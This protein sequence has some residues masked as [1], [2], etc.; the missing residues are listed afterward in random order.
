MSVYA[1][2]RLPE[3]LAKRLEAISGLAGRAAT[4]GELVGLATSARGAISDPE[5]LCCADDSRHEIRIGD[6]TRHTH[7]VIDSLILPVILG[8]QAVVRS[9]SP[10][11]GAVVVLHVRPDGVDVDPAGAVVSFGL[12]REGSGAFYE[13][14]CPYINAFESMDEY[15]RWA[16]ATPE[17]VTIAMPVADAFA[18]GRAFAGK[19]C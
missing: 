13:V 5:A 16:A 14:G 3:A 17:A 10:L 19:G 15:E 12:S 2:K 6:Q 4:L 1:T 9:V 7:C 8:Q 11:S 18:L